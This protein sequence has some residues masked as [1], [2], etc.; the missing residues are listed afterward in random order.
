MSVTVACVVRHHLQSVHMVN[1]WNTDVFILFG[2]VKFHAGFLRAVTNNV[3]KTQ[4]QQQ[5]EK[6]MKLERPCF[7]QA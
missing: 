7:A 3:F 2:K 6:P 5:K 4:M 1:G